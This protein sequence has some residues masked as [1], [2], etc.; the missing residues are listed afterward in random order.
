VAIVSCVVVGYGVVVIVAIGA[1]GYKFVR[2]HMGYVRAATNPRKQSMEM[3][4]LVARTDD[5]DDDDDLNAAKNV[6]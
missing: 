6:F 4:D 1:M 3:D 2:R 5:D